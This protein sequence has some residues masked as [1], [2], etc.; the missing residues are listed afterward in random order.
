[1]NGIGDACEFDS[2]NDG[3]SDSI[4]NAIHM[5]NPDQKDTDS[6]GIGDIMDNCL[7]YNPDQL[8]INKNGK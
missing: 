3:I 6:D 4:D 1:V 7:L 2:D 8:D 5:K